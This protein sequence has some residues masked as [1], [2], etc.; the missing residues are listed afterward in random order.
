MN[1][2]EQINRIQSM[3]GLIIEGKQKSNTPVQ[4]FK[5]GGGSDFADKY[6]GDIEKIPVIDTVRNEPFKDMSYM[7]EK[8]KT[9]IDALN[10]G[11]EWMNKP[12]VAIVHPYDSS[13]Y[14]VV[15]GNHRLYAYK[16][17]NTPEV[18][19]IIV[20]HEDVVLMKSD[21]G[22]KNEESIN[23]TDV[24]NNKKIIDKYFV[25]PDGTNNFKSTDEPEEIIESDP[26]VGTGK[27]PKGSDRRLYTD[28]NPKDTVSVKFRTK[29]DIVDTLNKES[30]K[31]KSHARKSQIINLIHQRLRVAL[32]RAKDPEVKKRLKTAF[33]Y[34]EQK[35]EQSKRKTQE[36]KEG[37]D[38][39]IKCDCGWSWKLED[40]GNDPYTCHKCGKVNTKEELTEKCWSGYT[41]KGMKTMFGKRYPNCV[42]KK[43]K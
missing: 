16:E 14:V 27:K 37:D 8:G 35:K 20:P 39:K 21:W 6:Q 36:M 7:K 17:T 1:L 19:A 15:D 22:D 4:I 40:G 26:K 24:I 3:M 41:Q 33:E 43:K 42:K 11:E 32:Q 5:D 10:N 29:Q 9:Y 18:N 30:F 13:K 34:I 2:Q 23:L 28:E 38:R 31:S 25:K 12:I